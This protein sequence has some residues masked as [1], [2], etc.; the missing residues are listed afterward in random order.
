[1]GKPVC[2]L[3]L[4]W[5]CRTNRGLARF[6]LIR[7]NPL[8]VCCVW[9]TVEFTLNLEGDVVTV[10]DWYAVA[11]IDEFW[12]GGADLWWWWW[13]TGP[14]GEKLDILGCNSHILSSMA[15]SVQY[16]HFNMGSTQIFLIL[17]TTY[18]IM[19]DFIISA[20][21]IKDDLSGTFQP[22][23]KPLYRYQHSTWFGNSAFCNA[24]K[25]R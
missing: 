18:L 23:L 2:M 12:P 20:Y 13:L 1:M 17:H 21:S 7:G 11:D 3:R 24:S 10:G 22:A 25:E 15:S 19:F 9:L 4:I 5:F 6:S 14:P 8:A 16:L